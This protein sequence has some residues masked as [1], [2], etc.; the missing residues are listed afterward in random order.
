M[1]ISE[2][3]TNRSLPP[4]EFPAGFVITYNEKHLSNEKEILNLMENIMYPYIKDVKKS[5]GP[6]F[7]KN[8]YFC[9]MHLRH[10]I[11]I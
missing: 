6:M 1:F 7:H 3:K 9:E 11:Q 4:V 8:V 10:R 2:G 5:W